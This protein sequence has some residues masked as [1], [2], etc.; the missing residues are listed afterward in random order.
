MKRRIVVGF[1]ASLAI[2]TL[3]GCASTPQATT[4]TPTE[5]T[6]EPSEVLRVGSEGD[7]PPFSQQNPDGTLSGFD[8]DIAN[9]LCEK[10]QVKCE[11]VVNEWPT[12]IPSLNAGKY[13]VIISSMSINDERRQQ[14]LFTQPYYKSG[15]AFIAPKDVTFELTEAGLADKTICVFKNSIGNP[16]IEQTSPQ[17]QLLQYD[18][19]QTL[20]TDFF[21]GRCDAAFDTKL[22][23]QGILD[24]EGGEDYHFVGEELKEPIFGE[25]AGI[26]VRKDDQALAD[27]LNQAIDELYTDGTFQEINNKYFPFYIGAK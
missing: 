18:D 9:A 27:R 7:Y 19:T 15:Y 10:M 6:S 4:E 11:F 5:A 1:S 12:I 8:I 26:A 2:A 22:S 16:W 20:R 24:A 25:G 3:L 23:M 13:D 14:V 21:A 17:A